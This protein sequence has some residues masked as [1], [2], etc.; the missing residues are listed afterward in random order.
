MNYLFAA[1]MAIWIL[2][3]VYTLYLGH[4]QSNLT[5]ELEL[6]K[7]ALKEKSR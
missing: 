5:K 2:I 1:Y 3:F 4:R 6:L 7:T